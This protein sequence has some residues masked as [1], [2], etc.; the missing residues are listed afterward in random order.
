M[1]KLF[2]TTATA[3]LIGSAPAFAQGA[4]SAEQQPAA[5]SVPDPNQVVCEKQEETGSR[6]AARR[7]CKTRAEWAEERRLNRQDI[8]KMQTQRDLPH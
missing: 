7:V 6:L 1:R 3:L 4:Q 8:E 5:K 2:M